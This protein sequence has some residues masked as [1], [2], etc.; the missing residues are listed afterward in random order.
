MVRS[1]WLV[2]VAAATV[3]ASL[4]CLHAQQP[5]PQSGFGAP[6]RGCTLELV[7]HGKKAGWVVRLKEEQKARFARLP[8][9]ATRKE[10][11]KACERFLDR[12]SEVRNQKSGGK[13]HEKG[14]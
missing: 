3:F 11:W 6:G 4:R 13:K 9:P 5:A 12:K 7:Q 2:V 8:W 1:S 14:S 10:A